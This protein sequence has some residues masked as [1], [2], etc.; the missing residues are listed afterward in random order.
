[1]WR[2]CRHAEYRRCTWYFLLETRG[3]CIAV[4]TD[5]LFL[6]FISGILKWVTLFKVY[7]NKNKEN[8]NVFSHLNKTVIKNLL[9]IHACGGCDTISSVFNQGKGAI[10]SLIEKGNLKILNACAIVDYPLA[11][12]KDIVELDLGYL[13]WCMVWFVHLVFLSEYLMQFRPI[14][15]RH[16]EKRQGVL[17]G[18][19]LAWNGLKSTAKI[20]GF[21]KQN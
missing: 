9:L 3:D 6:L 11:T 2:W 12:Q 13:L 19:L 10:L 4:N 7:L 20:Q 14:F 8:R 17:W 21:L 1:M 15:P 5:I 16:V 18:V